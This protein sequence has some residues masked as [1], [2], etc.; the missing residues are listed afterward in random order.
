VD[1]KTWASAQTPPITR[2]LSTIFQKL[3]FEVIEGVVRRPVK[4]SVQEEVR[5]PVEVDAASL[6][7]QPVKEQVG[8]KE[9]L[10]VAGKEVEKLQKLTS[11][12]TTIEFDS[13]VNWHSQEKM[14]TPLL[15]LLEQLPHKVTQEGEKRIYDFTKPEAEKS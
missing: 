8:Q 12:F 11:V 1:M 14:K 15:Q 10:S 7:P 3:G 13:L 5:I 4:P 6:A 2:D 9:D